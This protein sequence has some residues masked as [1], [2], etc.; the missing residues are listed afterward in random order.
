MNFNNATMRT[1]TTLLRQNRIL[2]SFLFCLAFIRLFVADWYG[3]PSGSMYPTLLIGDR[4]ISNRMAYDIR[5]PFT[6]TILLRLHEPRRGDIVTFMSPDDGMHL[7]KRIVAIPGDT[8]SM[9]NNILEINGVR[10]A[11]GEADP[12]IAGHRVPG[13]DDEQIVREERI[14]GED[15]AILLMPGRK[16]FRDFGPVTIPAGEYVVLGDNRDNSKDSRYLGF[17]RRGLLTGR[18]TRVAFSFDP[19]RGY[20]PRWERFGVATE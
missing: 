9:R 7:V 10:A 13:Y 11:Y 2:L 1:L 4:V 19:D 16:A 18:V 12:D 20:R 8:V 3:V 17:I 5:L 14:F 6:E 15:H